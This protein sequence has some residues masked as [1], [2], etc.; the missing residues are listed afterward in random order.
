MTD[1]YGSQPPQIDPSQPIPQPPV[2]PYPAVYPPPK[3]GPSALKIVLIIVAIFVGLG[4]I[5]AGFVCYGIYKFTKSANITASSQPLTESDLGVALY[6]GAEQGKA[7]VRMTIAGKN[8][9]TATF[10]T[11]DSK[12]QVIAFYQNNLGPD[13]QI[14]TNING[15]TFVLNKRNGEL[16][17]VGVSQSPSLQGGRTQIVV[18]HATKA[19]AQSN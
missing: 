4:L 3:K 18:M 8:M 1:I 19:A 9:I 17:T 16:L 12:D 6:P 13:A 5:G 14:S 11:S 2:Q 7:S 15:E 10:L